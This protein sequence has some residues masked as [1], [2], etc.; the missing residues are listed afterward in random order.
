M[1]ADTSRPIISIPTKQHQPFFLRAVSASL[2]LCLASFLSRVFFFLAP[3][4]PR[5]VP[6]S[7]FFLSCVVCALQFGCKDLPLTSADSSLEPSSQT[8]NHRE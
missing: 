7:L 6:V 1:Y 8:V 2:F 4:V 5:A 3:F